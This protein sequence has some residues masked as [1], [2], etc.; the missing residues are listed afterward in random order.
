MLEREC[1][2][3]IES[4]ISASN[5]RNELARL[6][7]ALTNF[8]LRGSSI[9]FDENEFSDEHK[10]LAQSL[11]LL[12]GQY[13]ELKNFSI[14]LSLGNLTGDS[15]ARGNWL[16]GPLKSLQAQMLHLSWQ[17]K[18]VAD[19]D[20]NQVV[21][22]MGDFS[23]AFNRMIYQLG[24]REKQL[25]QGRKAMRTVLEHTPNGVVVIDCATRNVLYKNKAAHNFLELNLIGNEGNQTIEEV[26]ANFNE[27][28]SDGLTWELSCENALH[29][30]VHSNPII[31]LHNAA[32][33]HTLRDVTEEKQAE[34]ELRT[35]AY[36]DSSTGVG[37]RNS[38]LEYLAKQ[39]E[40]QK[41]FIAVFVD[42]DGL[43]YINDTF[44]HVAGD[45]ALRELAQTLDGA[46]RNNDCVFRMGGDEFLIVL[47]KTDK[48]IAERIITRVRSILSTKNEQIDYDIAFSVGSYLYDGSES[49]GV[50]ELLQ[51]VDSMMYLE[52]RK[53]K[54][55][56]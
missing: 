55:G 21:D 49:L 56:R 35:F 7:E 47:N 28:C 46:V 9:I 5:A 30:N 8:M 6:N 41:P 27:E 31:W 4:N 45:F 54:R 26:L 17:A 29:L 22:F 20:Y 36:Y 2:K 37:N 33:L 50:E 42:M 14:D 48:N 19:G 12:F 53:N 3:A 44:G 23:E 1:S 24:E 11:N 16:A 10:E 34:E 52:K 51:R 13:E 15:P 40:N 43:K 25:T 38:G 32:Y 18:Q 39:L